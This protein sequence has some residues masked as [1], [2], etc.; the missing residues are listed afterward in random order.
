MTG[1]DKTMLSVLINMKSIGIV[2]N[3]KKVEPMIIKPIES[4]IEI[5]LDRKERRLFTDDN[6][7][8]YICDITIRNTIYNQEVHIKLDEIMMSVLIDTFYY[9]ESNPSAGLKFN[10]I[11]I[12]IT[13]NGKIVTMNVYN[14]FNDNPL[15]QTVTF[16]TDLFEYFIDCCYFMFLIDIDDG[17]MTKYYNHYYQDMIE[18]SG[19]QYY[20]NI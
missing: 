20:G 13:N 16:D 12:M 9:A 10:D 6:M 14:T 11:N 7:S 5:V 15:H 2:Y 4:Y 17:D 18:C 8:S 3:E 19:G 1:V